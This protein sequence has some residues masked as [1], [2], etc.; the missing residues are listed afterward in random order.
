MTEILRKE[1]LGWTTVVKEGISEDQGSKKTC[2]DSKI[3]IGEN[4]EKGIYLGS[5]LRW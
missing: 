3:G 2:E 4:E 1:V 5:F